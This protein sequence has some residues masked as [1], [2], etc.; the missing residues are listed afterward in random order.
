MKKEINTKA[1]CCSR[2]HKILGLIALA[3]LFT[4]GLMLGGIWAGATMHNGSA[5]YKKQCD[6]IARQINQIASKDYIDDSNLERLESLNATYAKYCAGHTMSADDAPAKKSADEIAASA[7]KPTCVVIEEMM[8]GWL[9]DE[10]DTDPQ[11]HTHNIEVYQKLIANGCPE[12]AEKYQALI[13]R[14]QEILAALTGQAANTEKTCAEIETLL[15]QQL[16]TYNLNESDVRIDRAKIYA[17]LSERGCPENS[18]KYVELAAKELEIARALRD[19]EFNPNEAEEVVETYKRL[20]MKAAATD[21][22][23]KVQK[24]IDPGVDFII[25]MQKIIEE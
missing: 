14:E 3:G 17:N 19:D 1:A 6:G 2:G 15:M 10:M 4:C 24:L 9:W 16:P 20:E 23:N 25:Q 21:V 12:N 7:N 8:T 11:N 5:V 22:L 13:Q 18:Q